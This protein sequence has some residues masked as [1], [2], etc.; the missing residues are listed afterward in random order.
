MHAGLLRARRLGELRAVHAR[1]EERR[2]RRA[3]REPQGVEPKDR[4]VLRRAAGPRRAG[5]ALPPRRPRLPR[6]GG[7]QHG[8]RLWRRRGRRARVQL[9]DRAGRG[10]A[11][12][13]HGLGG[14]HLAQQVPPAVRDGVRGL[15]RRRLG[16]GHRHAALEAR[17]P[18]GGEQG[19]VRVRQRPPGVILPRR[20]AALLGHPYR[21]M[22]ARVAR[23]H[24]RHPGSRRVAGLLHAADGKRRQDVQ[25][26]QSLRGGEARR[27]HR[28]TAP[29]CCARPMNPPHAFDNETCREI[30][31]TRPP[32]SWVSLSLYPSIYLLPTPN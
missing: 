19:R 22:R 20:P 1:R 25:D 14:V 12:R 11:Q 7:G 31:R 13:A 26:V 15:Q 10:G 18:A 16:H 32:P 21:A 27:V 28:Q 17:A 24:P 9:G 5:G 4:R 6:G 23:A 29:E 2:H 8:R 30:P 3:G